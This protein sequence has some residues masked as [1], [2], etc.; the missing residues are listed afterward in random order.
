VIL[1][2]VRVSVPL[3]RD[4]FSRELQRVDDLRESLSSLLRTM[5]DDVVQHFVRRVCRRLR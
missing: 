3:Q 2:S 4:L 5:E 1:I